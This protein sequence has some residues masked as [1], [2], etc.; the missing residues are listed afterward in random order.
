VRL[1]DR[2]IGLLQLG[3]PALE[4]RVEHFKASENPNAYI[5]S[6]GFSRSRYGSMVHLLEL[7]A[8]QLAF[9]ANEICYRNFSNNNCAA[10]GAFEIR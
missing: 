5:D 6:A 2:I 7:F 3:R 10:A 9:F 1:G 4:A 8:N